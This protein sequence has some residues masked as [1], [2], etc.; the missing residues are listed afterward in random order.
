MYDSAFSL[1]EKNE[2]SKNC[3]MKRVSENFFSFI[4]LATIF[5][6]NLPRIDCNRRNT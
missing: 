3:G 5:V 6:K 1:L 2:I 4:N